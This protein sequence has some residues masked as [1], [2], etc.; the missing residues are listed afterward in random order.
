MKKSKLEMINWS[1]FLARGIVFSVVTLLCIFGCWSWLA[2]RGLHQDEIWATKVRKQ[3]NFDETRTW[4]LNAL[5][6]TDY[7]TVEARFLLT[8]APVYLLKKNYKRNPDILVGFECIHLRY[9]GGMYSWGLTIGA[10]NLPESRARGHNV[11][12]W[13]PGIYY[14]NQ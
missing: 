14:W 1:K 6:L 2:W 12:R 7:D 10:S 11:K 8:N 5:R 3:I 9:G 13:V 4:A